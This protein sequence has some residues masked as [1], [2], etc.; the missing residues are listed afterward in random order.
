MPDMAEHALFYNSKNGDRV[1][2]A[3]SFEHLLKKF[4]TSG[5]FVGDLTVRSDEGMSVSVGTGYCN[6]DGKV[7]FFSSVGYLPIATAHATLTRTDAIVA[8]R[9]DTER[10][11]TLKVVTGT[12][13]GPAPIPVRSGG[14]YQLVLAHVA[15]PGGVSSVT[16]DMIIDKRLDPEVCGAV[17]AAV[18]NVDFSQMFLQFRAQFDEWFAEVRETLSDDVAGNLMNLIVELQERAPQPSAE[19]RGKYLRGDGTW[20]SPVLSVSFNVAQDYVQ[21]RA[22]ISV[23]GV[24]PNM[25]ILNANIQNGV[26]GSAWTMTMGQDAITIEGTISAGGTVSLVLGESGET[27]RNVI[28]FDDKTSAMFITKRITKTG[29]SIDANG[30]L[31]QEIDIPNYEGYSSLAIADFRSSVSSIAY[32]GV[33]F[34]TS[35]R[36]LRVR[37]RNVTASKVTGVEVYITVLYAKNGTMKE[38]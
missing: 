34:D 5:V 35:I 20:H 24:T 1:Y 30:Y 16:Q 12:P 21:S 3:S 9:N 7:R 22:P 17:A 37:L 28:P 31:N 2:D 36:K 23:P 10:D 26:Q 6:C 38:M 8:E 4:F 25:V 32:Y 18:E 13:G 27:V 14:I 29:M 33:S 19:D 11:I 15:V